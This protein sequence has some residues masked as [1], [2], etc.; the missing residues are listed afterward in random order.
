MVGRRQEEV[1]NSK[2]NVEAKEL[3]YMTHGQELQE[4]MWE[5]GGR[6]DE[7]GEMGQL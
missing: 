3:I 2:G 6:Q 4:G 7:W 1:K 5:G